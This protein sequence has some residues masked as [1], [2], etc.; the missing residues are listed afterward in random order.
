MS[1][2]ESELMNV[3]RK[4]LA[5]SFLYSINIYIQLHFLGLSSLLW[6]ELCSPPKDT[7]ALILQ[8]RP[9]LETR[10]LQT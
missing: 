1:R 10:S 7:E 6:F 9:C 5:F 3:L 2:N 8:M 4:V